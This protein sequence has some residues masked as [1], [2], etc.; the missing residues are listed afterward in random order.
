[1]HRAVS[2]LLIGCRQI[3]LETWYF[4]CFHLG[5]MTEKSSKKKGLFL[6]FSL[7]VGPNVATFEDTN[8]VMFAFLG[9]KFR[10]NCQSCNYLFPHDML[11]F[12]EKHSNPPM[13]TDSSDRKCLWEAEGGGWTSKDQR[14]GLFF[15][16]LSCKSRNTGKKKSRLVPK[17]SQSPSQWLI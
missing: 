17:C 15:P 13:E 2:V 16:H 11:A 1:M 14:V 9:Y 12:M 3:Q 5:W 10:R 4:S 8:F 6:A 7:P